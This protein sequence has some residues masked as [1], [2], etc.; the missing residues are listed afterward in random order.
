MHIST[1]MNDSKLKLADRRQMKRETDQHHH[2][3][4]RG[5]A[6][7]RLRRPLQMTAAYTQSTTHTGSFYFLNQSFTEAKRLNFGLSL[8]SRL[9]TG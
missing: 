4:G 3:A 9:T 7:A 6:R 2:Q 5:N 8:E 1:N